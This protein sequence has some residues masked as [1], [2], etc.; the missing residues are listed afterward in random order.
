M[1]RE[2]RGDE[3]DLQEDG[4]SSHH[5]GDPQEDLLS[6]EG[7]R[8]RDVPPGAPGKLDPHPRDQSGHDVVDRHR[9][10]S[11][12]EP[13]RQDHG[14]QACRE[15]A[16]DGPGR[17]AGPDDHP[18]TQLQG[19]HRA[20]A[21]D[22]ARVEPRTQ[23]L[24]G[25]GARRDATEVDHP[26]DPGLAGCVGEALRPAQLVLGPARPRRAHA[27]DQVVRGLAAL[28]RAHQGSGIAD[29]AADPVVAGPP[30]PRPS[31]LRVRQRTEWP[32]CTRGACRFWPMK[33][34]APVRRIRSGMSP[35]TL[36]QSG[37][38]CHLAWTCPSPSPAGCWA[39]HGSD[40]PEAGPRSSSSRRWRRRGSSWAIRVRGVSFG[41]AQGP[42]RS[43]RQAAL[44]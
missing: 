39:S 1:G 30:G 35:H 27:V 18:G 13:R 4:P 12:G 26:P 22:L 19:R 38:A 28:H 14:G 16:H 17:A 20:A 40:S 44:R 10:A 37:Y 11:I 5:R 2:A 36:L 15:V 25:L 6:G 8:A 29:V 31:G 24:G 3:R 23:V 7:L 21:E 41:P 32:A 9:L 34:V 42:W 33:P 43:A